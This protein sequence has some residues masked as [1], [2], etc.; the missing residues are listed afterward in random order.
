MIDRYTEFAYDLGLHADMTAYQV[1][2]LLVFLDNKGVK[3]EELLKEIYGE[4]DE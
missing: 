2:E 1:K 4:D 3:H